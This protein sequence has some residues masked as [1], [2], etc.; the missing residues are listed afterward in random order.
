MKT[1]KECVNG[2]IFPQ[3]Q[4]RFIIIG[5]TRSGK[6]T[7]A[8]NIFRLP[9]YSHVVIVDPKHKWGYVNDRDTI[10]E[11][12]KQRKLYLATNLPELKRA[13][14]RAADDGKPVVY[15]VPEADLLPRNS[16]NLDKVAHWVRQRKHTTLYY[17]ELSFVASATD[18]M[19][20][21]PQFYYALVTGEADD[22]GIMGC[23]Q[24]AR[25]IP[26]SALSE[27]TVRATFFLRRASDRHYVEDFM[28]E[29]IPWEYLQTHKYTFC[30]ADDMH[31]SPPM[32]LKLE[33]A[34]LPG[35]ERKLIA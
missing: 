4:Q 7:L 9:Q 17:D 23:I 12:V 19:Q 25:W 32:Y 31:A 11:Q 13:F 20:R 8:E 26:I 22:I 14:L 1:A 29:N 15:R 10:K 6:T 16:A 30:M 18:F 27:S 35:S 2:L 24:R 21:A 28:G 5:P 3:P 34:P 33:H